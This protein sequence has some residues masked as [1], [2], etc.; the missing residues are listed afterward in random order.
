MTNDERLKTM[1]NELSLLRAQLGRMRAMN[2][3]YHALFF[4][5]INFWILICV[6]LLVASLWE[7]LRAAVFFVP[8]LVLYAAMQGAFHFHY[9][10]L[11]RRYARALEEKLNAMAGK[12]LLIAN[13]LEEAYL[14]KLDAPRFVGFSFGSPT[15]FFSAITLHYGI[16]GTILWALG[17][18]VAL[19]LTPQYANAMPLLWLYV[20]AM[21]LWTLANMGYLAWYFIARRDEKNVQGILD[22]WNVQ[23]Q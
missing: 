9:I 15:S 13:Q 18:V 23:V 22:K 5:S 8:P 21:L 3:K 11:T 4:R 7:P 6:G 16:A 17:L 12:Q 1:S 2:F 19:M 14:M 10:L 20:P